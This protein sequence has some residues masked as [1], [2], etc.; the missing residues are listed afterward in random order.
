MKEKSCLNGSIVKSFFL[1][2]SAYWSLLNVLNIVSSNNLKMLKKFEQNNNCLK[3][4]GLWD[5]P[6]K[7]QRKK[8]LRKHCV[9]LDES[10]EML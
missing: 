7:R 1:L 10:A 5:D 6:E 9:S 8:V 3:E 2:T 4:L